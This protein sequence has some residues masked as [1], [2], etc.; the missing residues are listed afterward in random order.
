MNAFSMVAVT[1]LASAAI[2]IAIVWLVQ[3][4]KL[5]RMLATAGRVAASDQRLAAMEK[6]LAALE[7]IAVDPAQRLA[8]EIA[9]LEDKAA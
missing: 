7:T 9:E 5:A 3:R 1:V 2:P 8:R 6:R 4:G